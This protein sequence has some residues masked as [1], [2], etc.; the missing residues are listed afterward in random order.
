MD[1][2]SFLSLLII[3]NGSYDADDCEAEE[4]DAEEEVNGN[5]DD[6]DEEG[7][8][9][10][11]E[12]MEDGVGLGAVYQENLDDLSDEGDYEAIEEEDEE[13][14]LEDEEEEEG[15][16]DDVNSSEGNY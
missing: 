10:D 9:E 11:D 16:E 6:S 5:D 14:G 12:E 1:F 4:T 3:F 2:L 15:L 13:D 8:S 7:S